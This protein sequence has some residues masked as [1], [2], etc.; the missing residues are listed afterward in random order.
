M[1]SATPRRPIRF[2]MQP[3]LRG[4]AVGDIRTSIRLPIR[5][6]AKRTD[7]EIRLVFRRTET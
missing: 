2:R 6:S 5:F 1:N 4:P 7:R 3:E